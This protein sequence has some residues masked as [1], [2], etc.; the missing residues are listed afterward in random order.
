MPPFQTL[1][2]ADGHDFTTYVAKPDDTPYGAVVVIQEIFGVNAHIREVADR[3]AAAGYLAVAPA[4]FDRDRPGVELAYDADGGG[5]RD[6]K[7]AVDSN[8]EADV[9]A[10]ITFCR[11]AGQLHD[12][13]GVGPGVAPRVPC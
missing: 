12:F 4:L 6:L 13:V 3:F 8:S 10:A 1:T 2:A 11:S 9:M 5:R 7:E